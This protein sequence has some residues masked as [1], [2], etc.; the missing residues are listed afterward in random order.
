MNVQSLFIDYDGTIVD[1]VGLWVKAVNETLAD[2]HS[3][4]LTKHDLSSKDLWE[5]L[6]ERLG[7]DLWQINRHASHIWQKFAQKSAHGWRLFDG[8]DSTLR[9]LRG[10]GFKLVLVS[11]RA[12]DAAKRTR[13]ELKRYGI[14]HLFNHIYLNIQHE[15]YG[16]KLR[17]ILSVLNFEPWQVAVISDWV[18]DLRVAKEIGFRTIGVLSG[19]S[20]RKEFAEAKVEVVIKSLNVVPQIVL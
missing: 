6:H 8:A 4:P 12:G 17:E 7:K 1:S 20:I 10:N 14:D 11:K 19:V 16:R 5:I 13:A 2:T 9:Q 15:A 18:A 3:S